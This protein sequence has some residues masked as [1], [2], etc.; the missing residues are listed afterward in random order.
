M[1]FSEYI[2]AANERVF[3]SAR[4][5][6]TPRTLRYGG[7]QYEEIPVVLQACRAEERTPARANGN[8]DRAQG[9]YR[10]ARV[11]HF[12]L[13]DVDGTPPEQGQ[14]LQISEGTGGYYAQFIVAAVA[15]DFGMVR[16]ELE[17]VEE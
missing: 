5:F 17:G 1:S 8:S 6:A 2:E 9:L 15:V 11:A 14:R 13:R 16:C 10:T 3:L 4:A 12:A 7:E